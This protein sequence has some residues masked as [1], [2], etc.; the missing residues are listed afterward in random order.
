MSVASKGRRHITLNR[1]LQLL[2]PLEIN[3]PP[4]PKTDN[5]KPLNLPG[6]I[7]LENA[8]GETERSNASEKPRRPQRSAAK[9][10]EERR[11]TWITQLEED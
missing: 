9:E 8:S 10:G 1:P 5:P 11:R 7:E 2:Y 6:V 4:D 3:H